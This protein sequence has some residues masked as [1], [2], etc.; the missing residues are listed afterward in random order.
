MTM[1]I[2]QYHQNNGIQRTDPTYGCLRISQIN[3]DVSK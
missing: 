2:L 3:Q 1:K